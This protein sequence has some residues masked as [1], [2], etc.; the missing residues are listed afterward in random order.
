MKG[1]RNVA[2]SVKQRLLNRARER[3][4]EFNLLLH[5]FGA[6]RLLYRLSRSEHGPEFVLKG[7]MLF[8]AWSEAPHRP[9]L[10]IDLLG[11]GTPDLPRL[12]AVFRSVCRVR[13]EMDG[14]EFLADSVRAGR[15][16]EDAKYEGVRVRLEARLGSA[17]ISLQIDV[18][19]GDSI[20]PPPEQIDFPVLLDHPAPRLTAYRPE[21]VIAEK[22]HAM[23]DLGM[24]NSRMKDFFDLRFLA[25]T[26]DFD[27]AKLAH[28][29]EATFKQRGTPAPEAPPTAFTPAFAEDSAKMAQWRGFLRRSRLL[30]ESLTLQEAVADLREFILPLLA[31]LAAG[32][33]FDREWSAGGPWR[34]IVG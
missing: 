11:R 24:A 2:A 26:F 29:V 21:T 7:A 9:T 30:P 23:V 19:F 34:R 22:L 25:A 10:D 17:R 13:V 4:E 18:G 12:E 6:E 5:R 28:A 8:C 1:E 16:R 31:S 32:E 15:I 33:N 14:L 20:V 27:G 3:S